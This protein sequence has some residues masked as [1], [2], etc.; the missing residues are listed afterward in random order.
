M[1]NLTWKINSLTVYIKHFSLLAVDKMT[2]CRVLVLCL[3]ADVS[4]NPM[5]SRGT[6][7]MKYVKNMNLNGITISLKFSLAHILFIIHKK[8]LFRIH[9]SFKKKFEL[10]VRDY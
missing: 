4:E 8:N 5:C 9:M 6:A 2:W 1:E 7:F 10:G 3:S